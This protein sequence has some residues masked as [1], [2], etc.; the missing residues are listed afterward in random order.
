M[1]MHK[2]ERL[3]MNAHG[4]HNAATH[5]D[6]WRTTAS[7]VLEYEDNVDKEAFEGR[8]KTVA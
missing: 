5:D 6:L 2:R 1:W 7:G 8:K 3:Q 4:R